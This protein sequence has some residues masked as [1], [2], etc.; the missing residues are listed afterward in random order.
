[1]EESDDPDPPDERDGILR[2]LEEDDDDD[3]GVSTL[4]PSLVSSSIPSLNSQIARMRQYWG[5]NGS[6]GSI[7]YEPPPVPPRRDDSAKFSNSSFEN[8]G[9]SV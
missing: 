2:P 7:D 9:W 4:T 8:Y 1:M 5:Y 3:D 6:N